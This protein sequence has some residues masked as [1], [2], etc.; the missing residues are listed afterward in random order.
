AAAPMELPARRTWTLKP[1]TAR[2]F[3]SATA[4]R[5]GRLGFTT[6]PPPEA[7]AASPLAASLLFNSSGV[8]PLTNTSYWS[9][10]AAGV[11]GAGAAAFGVLVAAAAARVFVT[12]SSTLKL[13]L[14]SLAAR[15]FAVSASLKAPTC[16]QNAP[17]T[18]DGLGAGVV[19]TAAARFGVAA[20]F[21][22]TAGLGSAFATISGLAS[23][24][25][26]ASVFVASLA[27]VSLAGASFAAESLAAV[28]FAAASVLGVG[29]GFAAGLA[30][31][32]ASFGGGVG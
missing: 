24:F 10:A 20:G 6:M 31:G 12:D 28:S 29:A 11:F 19:A 16:T 15:R 9:D 2:S 4:S 8:S 32:A 26:A 14:R 5:R 25:T 17:L 23:A 1:S 3:E 21:V 7:S 18:G 13:S 30:V 27:A 22:A